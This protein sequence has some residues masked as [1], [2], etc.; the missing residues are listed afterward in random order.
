MLDGNRPS[1]VK[2]LATPVRHPGRKPACC[3][4]V[5]HRSRR[6][7]N[8]RSGFWS[9]SVVFIAGYSVSVVAPPDGA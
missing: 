6:G 3:S 7:E 4:A 5:A 2:P 9:I 8:F 1:W